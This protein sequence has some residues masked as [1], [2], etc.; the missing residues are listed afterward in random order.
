MRVRY[1]NPLSLD[2]NPAI[3]AIAY[4]L[5]HVMKKKALSALLVASLLYATGYTW[6]RFSYVETWDR[7]G[8]VY[9][10][11][12]HA[13]LYYLYRPVSYLDSALTG[14]RFHIGPHR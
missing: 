9:L 7:D 6:L 5:Q 10:L 4:G 8:Q 14:M 12:P 13:S 3:D 2:A 1:V 11:F